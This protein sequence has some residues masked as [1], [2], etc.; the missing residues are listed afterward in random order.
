MSRYPTLRGLIKKYKMAVNT[1]S[2]LCLSDKRNCFL[3]SHWRSRLSRSINIVRP[4]IAK[5]LLVLQV[6]HND[7][8]RSA[9]HLLKILD[10]SLITFPHLSLGILNYEEKYQY[11]YQK[12]NNNDQRSLHATT[13]TKAAVSH[14]LT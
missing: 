1:R 14:I 4:N 6:I 7:L 11:H 13:S 8:F 12:I 3:T 9:R 10:D 5:M 2:Y